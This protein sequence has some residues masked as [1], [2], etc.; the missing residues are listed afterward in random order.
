VNAVEPIQILLVED[1]PADVR[2]TQEVMKDGKVAN[3]LHVASDGEQALAFMRREGQYRDA[4]RPDLV[5]LDLNLPRM[6][7]REV[8]DAIK[9]DEK[10]KKIPVIMLTTSGA[11]ADILK[12]YEHNVNAYVTKPIDLDEFVGVVRSIE[13]FWL[14]IVKLPDGIGEE[15]RR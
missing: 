14:S 1:H 8:L 3:D 2:L 5:I 11:D 7:G 12:A 15:G 4:P 6:N 9:G 10:L 13:S